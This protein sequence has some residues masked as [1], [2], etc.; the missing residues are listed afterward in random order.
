MVE[1][2]RLQELRIKEEEQRKKKEDEERQRK[3]REENEAIEK[4]R[5]EIGREIEGDEG[6]TIWIMW[7][8]GIFVICGVIAWLLAFFHERGLI[9]MAAFFWCLIFG[10]LVFGVGFSYISL[11]LFPDWRRRKRLERWKE[12]HPN[13]WR[14]KY[15]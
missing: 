1:Q 10:E 8:L 3:Q 13:D 2:K 12:K 7:A 11:S 15:L 4:L 14:A 5:R 6:C 9:S